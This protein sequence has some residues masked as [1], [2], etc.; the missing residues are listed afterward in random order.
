M[1]LG[2]QVLA[3]ARAAID[4]ANLKDVKEIATK[5]YDHIGVYFLVDTLKY[6]HAGGRIAAP[7]VGLALH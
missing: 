6:L 5:A 3:A 2:F 4:G 1:A 7:N